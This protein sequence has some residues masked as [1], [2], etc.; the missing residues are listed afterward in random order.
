MVQVSKPLVIKKEI[1]VENASELI[2]SLDLAIADYHCTNNNYEKG[3]NLYR[4]IIS[5][6]FGNER[7]VI[8]DKYI[9]H[10][11]KYGQ[12]LTNNQK[13]IEAMKEWLKN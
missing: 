13:Y 3:L 1:P 10:S 9:N 8:V 12:V 2:S 11:L 5:K 4:E 7:N 6:S